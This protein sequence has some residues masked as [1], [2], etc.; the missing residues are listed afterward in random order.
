MKLGS[1]PQRSTKES[2]NLCQAVQ[3]QGEAWIEQG[4]NVGE[5][6]ST[7]KLQGGHLPAINGV[8]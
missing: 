8:K 7:S 2:G 5:I 6:F 3:P 1:A 4:D